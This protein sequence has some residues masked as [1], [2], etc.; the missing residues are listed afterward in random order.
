MRGSVIRLICLRDLRDQL[1]DRRTV[2]MIALLPL[3]LYPILG[4]ALM[5]FA[6][7]FATQPSKIG[8]VGRG[9][10]FPPPQELRS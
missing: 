5:T 3:V 10:D 1:R 9:P 8:I 2:L 7:G 4:I 6:T